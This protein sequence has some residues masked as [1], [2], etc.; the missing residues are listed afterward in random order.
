MVVVVVV[1]VVAVV[2][3]VVV[4]V[5]AVAE[6]AVAVGVGSWQTCA[7]RCGWV[8]RWGPPWRTARLPS[9]LAELSHPDR[10]ARC[11]KSSRAARARQTCTSR[12]IQ[13]QEPLARVQA[14]QRVLCL[15]APLAYH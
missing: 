9:R 14:S 13:A 2:M 11:N 1:A 7:R 3:A 12:N 15:R 4:A 5:V 10:L 8:G 6:V